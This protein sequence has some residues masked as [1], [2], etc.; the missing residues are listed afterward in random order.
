MA[1]GDYGKTLSEDLKDLKNIAGDANRVFDALD[2]RYKQLS[3]SSGKIADRFKDTLDIVYLLF[4]ISAF[5]FNVG[6]DKSRGL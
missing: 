4:I 3:K 2:S 1:A 6:E 5:E